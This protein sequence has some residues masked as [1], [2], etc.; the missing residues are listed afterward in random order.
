MLNLPLFFTLSTGMDQ[1]SF[2]SLEPLSAHPMPAVLSALLNLIMAALGF[3]LYYW[4]WKRRG[5]FT[6]GRWGPFT[7]GAVL[8][9]APVLLAHA[10][11]IV[12]AV[13]GG[14]ATQIAIAGLMAGSLTITHA[15][16]DPEMSLD[17]TLARYWFAGAL[18]SI[19]TFLCLSVGA[20][21]V[22]YS[23]EQTPDT[24]NLLW[25]WTTNWQNVGYPPEEFHQRW[26]NALTAFTISG[27][28]FM[29]VV[30]GGSMLG[31]ILGQTRARHNVKHPSPAGRRYQ[32]STGW[33]GQVISRLESLSA[34]APDEAEYVAV[35]DG[36]E[37]GITLGQYEY[38]VGGKDDLLRDAGL[39]INKVT[40]DVFLR[41]GGKWTKL[42]FRV[43]RRGPGIRS[44]PFA[45]LCIYA[46]HP[47]RRYT[48]G[49]LETLIRDDLADDR[50]SLN[51]TEFI[52][53][54]Q[55]GGRSRPGLPVLRD[56]ATSRFDAAVNVCLL[57]HR[58]SS[59]RSVNSPVV[60]MPST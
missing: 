57:D 30:L 20:M 51:V 4:L 58:P 8:S 47:G 52:S 11:V 16:R 19:L 41:S 43:R 24:G 56:G 35:F 18:A 6:G 15:L 1:Y 50:M 25:E 10:P 27:S 46:R 17:R 34:F 39:L 14:K 12:L 40:G 13:Q 7:R 53:Q 22:L 29:I 48:T 23:T 32:D 37:I 21:L 38:L 60:P 3:G 28:G 55:R 44:G 49:E 42:D 9:A 59:R 54:L 45:L 36:Y 31:A 2:Y 5:W 33:A 26:R